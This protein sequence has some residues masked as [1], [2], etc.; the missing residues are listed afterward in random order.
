MEIGF[1]KIS[2]RQIIDIRFLATLIIVTM[3]VFFLPLEKT[4]ISPIKVA[5][6]GFSVIIFILKVPYV[7]KALIWG[8]LYWAVCY[9][10][11]LFHESMRFSTI[12]Y[13]GLF[14]ITAIVFYHL[15]YSGA[16]IITYFIQLL[17]VLIYAYAIML[18]LQQLAML[19]GVHTFPPINLVGQ[20]FLS[21][22]KLPSL[23]LEPSHS[24]RLLTAMML[25]YIRCI[26]LINGRVKLT[27]NNLFE[28]KHR[29]VTILFLWTMLTMGSGTAFIGLGILS[30]YFIRRHTAVYMIPLLFILFSVGQLL[31]LKQMDR[32]VRV[33]QATLS[34]DV[35]A[36]QAEDG[37]AS[38][39]IIPVLNTL[40]IDL[41][42]KESWIGEGTSSYK[43]A[44]T[45]WMR[46]TDKIAVVEQYGL[47]AFFISLIWVYSCMIR[48]FFSIETLLFL[49]L[50]GMSL[51][52]IYHI[53]GALLICMVVRY[54][55]EAYDK[56]ILVL[57]NIGDE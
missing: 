35:K 24:A 37:S 1:P 29:W 41:T 42:Q 55:Q 21:L 34:G 22:T 19:V 5:V 40:T 38:S 23:T 39:R 33:G 45:G 53:W 2:L 10:T 20:S 14:V 32:V 13:L 51:T 6:M 7:S 15:V 16:F 31:E 8:M 27:V 30:F 18:V 49:A 26:E 57:N 48:K 12:G 56:G 25:G 11:A 4:V 17:K 46:T 50:W 54:F 44:T 52:N 28:R 36:V 9:F 43:K 47:I 3:C